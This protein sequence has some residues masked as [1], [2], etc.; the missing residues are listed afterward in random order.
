MD[1]RRGAKKVVLV[2]PVFNDW[3]AFER[4]IGEIDDLDLAAYELH[5]LA[6]DDGSSE[7]PDIPQ[8]T[9]PRR[10]LAEVRVIRLACNLGHQRAIAIGLVEASKM[11]GVAGVVVMDS[12]GE[13]RP[14]DVA[15]LLGVW[16]SQPDQIALATRTKRS[17]S[18][19]FRV[20]YFCYRILFRM[21]TGRGIRFGNFSLLPIGAVNALIHNASIWN[22]LAATVTRSGLRCVHVPTIRGT[23]Y[24]GESRMNVV[25]LAIHGVS[26]ISVY[27]DVV[28]VRVIAAACGL[29]A[30]VV[31][32]LVVVV[33]VRLFTDLAIPGWASYLGA[34]LFL[35]LVQAL[36]FAGI[37]LFQ[38]LSF[39]SVKTIVPAS[40]VDEFLAAPWQMPSPSASEAEPEDGR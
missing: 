11:K 15:K 13:D 3:T 31:L 26:A 5:V 23:R 25:S 7:P 30:V 22:N 34:S 38:L 21:L 10:S 18:L 37:A 12:D 9:R 28:L 16:E 32:G 29:A 4:L 1:E 27:S 35:I 14:D 40:D 39:R 20:L 6:V 33:G 24:A 17:E 2:T 8:L 19:S 36:M